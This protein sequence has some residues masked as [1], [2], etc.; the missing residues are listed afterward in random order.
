MWG[1]GSPDWGT[2]PANL[3]RGLEKEIRRPVC[4]VNFAESAYNLT[5]NV[6]TLLIQLQSGNRPDLVLFYNVEGDAFAAYQAGKAGTIQNLDQVAARFE[7]GEKPPTLLDRLRS[8]SSYSL[9]DGLV[10]KLTIANPE[11]DQ[12]TSNQ[13]V[14]YETMGIDVENLSNSIAQNYFRS[15]QIVDALSEKNGFKYFFFLPPHLL[16]GDK[17][18]LTLEEQQMKRVAE[19]DPAFKKLFK[20]VYRKIETESSKYP[21]LY[22]MIDTFDNYDSLIWIDAGHVTP[23]ANQLIAERILNIIQA[24]SYDKK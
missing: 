18:P 11:Q 21:N 2:I 4:V 12:P 14:T 3:Q 17:K 22:S 13:L 15:Y 5:Q 8:T 16:L 1:T 9:I 19:S 6:I 10:S 24:R 7:K 20:A 23:A